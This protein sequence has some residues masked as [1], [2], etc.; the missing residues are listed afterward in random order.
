MVGKLA[1]EMRKMLSDILDIS[2]MEHGL[3]KFCRKSRQPVALADSAAGTMAVMAEQQAKTVTLAIPAGLPEV[4]AD[5]GII[6]RVFENL[7]GNALRYAP[8]GSDV[9]I[10]A[11]ADPKEG[12]V[13]FSVADKG[14]GIKSKHLKKVFG[15]YFQSDPCTERARKGTGLGL[16][17]CSMA[18]A[19]HGG[20]IWAENISPKGCR[21][22]FTL[23]AVPRR[24][25]RRKT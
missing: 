8:K 17:F 24:A 11:A 9:Y 23:P 5:S 18:V 21:F 16:T 12:A 15:K 10:S 20:R 3:F 22:S 14:P 25:R 2:R 13:R 1:R 7:I 4:K 6:K 19:A